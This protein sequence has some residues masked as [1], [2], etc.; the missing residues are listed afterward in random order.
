MSASVSRR[1]ARKR[2]HSTAFSETNDAKVHQAEPANQVPEEPI[3]DEK[4]A[5]IWE[6]FREE[7]FESWCWS[8]R[9]LLIAE[10]RSLYK[11]IEQLPLSLHRQFTLMK[12]LEE[13]AQGDYTYLRVGNV[14]TMLLDNQKKLL[15][16]LQGYINIRKAL[17]ALSQSTTSNAV[18]PNIKV[19]CYDDEA[20]NDSVPISSSD[21]ADASPMNVDAPTQTVRLTACPELRNNHPPNSIADTSDIDG[22]KAR[23]LLMQVACL[24]EEIMRQSEE[25]VNLAQA[26]YDSVSRLPQHYRTSPFYVTTGG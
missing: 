13:N 25:K 6:S 21:E 23:Q 19:Q 26:I 22:S 20:T 9:K 24:S 14:M 3:S 15:P 7:N 10:E 2:R 11:A 12:E 4:E 16:Q 18:Q 17:A 8:I 5:E 1:S